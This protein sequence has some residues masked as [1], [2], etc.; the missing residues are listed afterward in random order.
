[1]FCINLPWVQHMSIFLIHHD[2]YLLTAG[3]PII[4]MLMMTFHLVTLSHGMMSS[5]HVHH[6]S[7]SSH[8]SR[9]HSPSHHM[10]YTSSSSSGSSS[11]PH[12]VQP[13]FS[14]P[15]GNQTVAVGRDAVF[16]C[17]IHNLKNYQV[18]SSSSCLLLLY[19]PAHHKSPSVHLMCITCLLWTLC[20]FCNHDF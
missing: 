9:L 14:E 5:S 12:E 3:I 17:V 1:M 18:S 16:T 7:T 2:T 13:H 20:D 6:K 11:S 8:V 15:M 4:I 19:P 10:S